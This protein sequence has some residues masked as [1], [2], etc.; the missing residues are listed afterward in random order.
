MFRKN[1]YERSNSASTKLITSKKLPS[2]FFTPTLSTFKKQN[3]SQS[4]L[5]VR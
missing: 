3:N 1:T 5:K 4:L 2:D